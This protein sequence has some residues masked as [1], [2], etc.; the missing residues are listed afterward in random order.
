MGISFPFTNADQEEG[1]QLPGIVLG[2]HQNCAVP[3]VCLIA[4]EFH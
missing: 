4:H 3:R 1:G 2:K